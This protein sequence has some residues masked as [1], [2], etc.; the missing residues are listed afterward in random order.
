MR[1]PQQALTRWASEMAQQ[2]E[3]AGGRREANPMGCP[4]TF[5]YSLWHFRARTL[6]LRQNSKYTHTHTHTHTHTQ[7]SKYTHTRTHTYIYVYIYE[8]IYTQ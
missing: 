8:Y 5:I 4:L 1:Q 3:V 6:T 2:V 7:N